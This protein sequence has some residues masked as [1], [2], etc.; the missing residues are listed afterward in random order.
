MTSEQR[1]EG[2]KGISGQMSGGKKVP[3]ERIAIVKECQVP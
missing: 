1:P 2:R 3:V